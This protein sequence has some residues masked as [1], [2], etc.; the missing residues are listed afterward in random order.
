[1]EQFSLT[2]DYKITQPSSVINFRSVSRSM[3]PDDSEQ[4]IEQYFFTHSWMGM[5]RYLM[6]CLDSAYYRCLWTLSFVLPKKLRVICPGELEDVGVDEED[7]NKLIH[8]Y[9]VKS[10]KSAQSI[11]FCCG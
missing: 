3:T 9:R 11:G 4:E 6:P 2:V 8:T 10:P 5:N 7:E 1:M